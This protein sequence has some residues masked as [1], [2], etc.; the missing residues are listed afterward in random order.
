MRDRAVDELNNSNIRG[1]LD[2]PKPC[3]AFAVIET[4]DW[5]LGRLHKEAPDAKVARLLQ[6]YE[7]IKP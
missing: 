4:L 6:E 5:V 2:D 7:K 3:E 1:H